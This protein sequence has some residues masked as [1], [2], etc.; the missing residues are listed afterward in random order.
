M[1]AVDS[2]MPLMTVHTKASLACC[3]SWFWGNIDV[4]AILVT[5]ATGG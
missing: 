3:V 5:S 4:L 2:L 1:L